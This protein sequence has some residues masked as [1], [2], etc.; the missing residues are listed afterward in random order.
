[1]HINCTV[2]VFVNDSTTEEFSVGRGLRQGDPLSPFLFLIAAKGPSVMFWKA[3]ALGIFSGYEF[4]SGSVC[5][6]HLKFIDNTLII[7]DRSYK[8][9]WV[10]KA[11]M[12]LFELVSGLKVDFHKSNLIGIH[13]SDLWLAEAAYLNCNRCL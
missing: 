13:V 8:N 12:Q 3:E 10:I 4:P 9:V 7:G 5:L 6:S 1:M 11:L 2:S